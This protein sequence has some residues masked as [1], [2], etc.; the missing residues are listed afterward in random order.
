MISIS[1]A[2]EYFNG[3]NE[4]FDTNIVFDKGNINIGENHFD[5]WQSIVS[6]ALEKAYKAVRPMSVLLPTILF[7]TRDL[8]MVLGLH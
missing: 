1:L 4:G 5:V 8:S 6:C 2:N 3:F 7:F